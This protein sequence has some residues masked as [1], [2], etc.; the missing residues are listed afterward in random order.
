MEAVTK[1]TGAK[2]IGLPDEEIVI[3]DNQRCILEHSLY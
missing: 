1:L 3:S 2:W